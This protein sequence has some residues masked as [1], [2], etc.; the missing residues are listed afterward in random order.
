MRRKAPGIV[1]RH[2]RQCPSRNGDGC[3]RPCSPTYQAWVYS[4][5]DGKKVTRSFPTPAA[6][7]AWRADALSAMNRGGFRAPSKVTLRAHSEEWLAKAKA[8]EILTRSHTQYKPAVIREIE[9]NLKLHVL[10]DLGAVRVS[11]IRRRDVQDLVDRLTADGKTGSTVR[12]VVNALKVINRRVLEH[13]EITVNPTSNLRLPATAGTR[14]RAADPAEIAELLTALR[15]ADRPLWSTAAYAGLRCGE[16]QALQ[17][18]QVD[19]D[20]KVIHVQRGWDRKEGVIGPKSR[21]GVRRV[22]IVNGLRL[23]LLEHKAS[24][25]RRGEDLVFGATARTP[26]TPSNAHKRARYSW[27]LE[28]ERRIEEA[29]E[30]VHDLEQFDESNVPQLVP[31]GLHELRHS[32]VSMLHA[33]GFTLE[34]IGDYVGHSSSYMT[35]RYRHLLAGHEEQAAK[36]FDAYLTGAH[37]GAQGLKAVY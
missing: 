1:E 12:N 27:R 8:G 11:A 28:N 34:E 16:L 20:A 37:T 21:K 3:G 4:A 30:A 22:P 23:I 15:D 18:D 5:K 17:W 26:F 25:G 10:D 6:A 29:R 13:D 24:T 2:H 19:L 35:D 32:Y 7:R 31:I 33:A 14:D 9:R 36:R